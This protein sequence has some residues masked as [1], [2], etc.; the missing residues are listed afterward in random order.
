MKRGQATVVSVVGVN[1]RTASVE[2][3][4]LL[5][6]SQREL[7]AALGRLRAELGGGVILSTCNRS[8]LYAAVPAD[9]DQGE[10]LIGLFLSLKGLRESIAPGRFYV[11]RHG[12]AVRHLYRVAAGID[13]MVLGEA[14]ILGQVRQALAEAGEAGSLNGVLSRLFHTAIRVGKR[15]RRETGIGRYALSVSATAVALARRTFG[16]LEQ[17]TVLVVSAG[18]TGKLAA[19]SLAQTGG[20][21]ILVTNRTY[22]RARELA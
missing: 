3:R 6:F 11:Y 15:A 19:R 17:R 12:E 2:Q 18:S 14:Q 10:A 1:H 20:A 16:R 9:A 13:S 4:E 7:S 5:A 21:R 22:D 8:E